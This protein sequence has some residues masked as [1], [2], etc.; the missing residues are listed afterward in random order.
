MKVSF[1]DYLKTSTEE[2]TPQIINFFSTE[3]KNVLTLTPKIKNLYTIYSESALGGKVLRGTL[4]KLGYQL[5]NPKF[6]PEILKV[7]AAVEILHAALLIHDDIADKSSTRRGKPSLYFALG[8][9]HYGISQALLLG[10]LGLYYPI[11]IISESGFEAR[12]KNEA[13]LNLSE[14]VV[15]T[16]LGEIL[17]VACSRSGE[18]KEEKDVLSIHKLKTAYYTISGPLSIG[19]LLA[20]G[21]QNQIQKITEFGRDLGIAFQIQDDILGVFGNELVLGKSVTS[22]VEEGKNTLLIIHALKK[23]SRDQKQFLNKY[24]GKGKIDISKYQIVREIFEKTG[25]LEYSRSIKM[26][27]VQKAKKNIPFLTKNQATRNL[28]VQLSDFLVNRS[29]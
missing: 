17:D 27:Y 29:K 23:A 21:S 4:V 26:K 22:D 12:L 9:D 8:Q 18:K 6:D 5:I 16:I 19:A 20:G 7:A 3:E 10:D 24:Y 25:S 2:I 11:K 14:I 28:L 15:K 1:N 13:I